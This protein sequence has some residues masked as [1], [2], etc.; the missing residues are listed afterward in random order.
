[1]KDYIAELERKKK[2]QKVWTALFVIG[3]MA[4][5]LFFLLNAT[6]INETVFKNK[7][8]DTTQK[9]EQNINDKIEVAVKD[10][11]ENFIKEI[12]K[13]DSII[14]E[15]EH[16]TERIQQV[17]ETIEEE[18]ASTAALIDTLEQAKKKTDLIIDKIKSIESSS[19]RAQSAEL[20]QVK[21][22]LLKVQNEL[23]SA[24]VLLAKKNVAVRSSSTEYV[25]Y[26]IFMNSHRR[27]A[28]KARTELRGVK[29]GKF[30]KLD[31]FSYNKSIRYFNDND[32][33][34]AKKL[35]RQL[36][37]MF[38]ADFEL[39]KL[40]LPSPENTMEVWIGKKE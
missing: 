23:K 22:E 26:I 18:R 13:K 9:L 14:S 33:S 11:T 38:N 15:K 36:E 39:R 10:S 25:V 27:Q 37:E 16:Y 31:K 19:G 29:I 35:K 2:R 4:V 34:E 6:K 40:N 20:V 7:I 1:M 28:V 3:F 32:L 21:S 5:S 17:V 30:E 8:A 12:E 24:P